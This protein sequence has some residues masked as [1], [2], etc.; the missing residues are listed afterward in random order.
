MPTGPMPRRL[1]PSA[2]LSGGTSSVRPA[3]I[4]SRGQD[5]SEDEADALVDEAFAENPC[6]PRE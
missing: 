5:I 1:A 6:G 4:G 3:E 2:K